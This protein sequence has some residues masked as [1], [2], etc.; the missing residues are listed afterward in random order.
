MFDYITEK[1]IIPQGHAHKIDEKK[2]ALDKVKKQ[3]SKLKS[4]NHRLDGRSQVPVELQE[5]LAVQGKLYR[6]FNWVLIRQ[7]AWKRKRKRLNRQY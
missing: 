3:I 4:E 2:K 1:I 7:N 6:T 5:K